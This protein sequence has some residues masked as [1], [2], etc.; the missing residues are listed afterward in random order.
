[1]P[2][3]SLYLSIDRGV[4]PGSGSFAG[5]TL[6]CHCSDDW[7]RVSIGSD[8]LDNHACGC[9]KCWKPHGAIFTVVG[10]VPRDS[11][12]VFDNGY[13]LAIVDEDAAVG[14]A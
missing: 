8:V 12:S 1:M 10:A 13:K 11:V 4:K 9:T 14:A 6:A 7:V 5:S 2:D 3:V